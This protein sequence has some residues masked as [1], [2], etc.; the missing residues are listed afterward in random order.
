MTPPRKKNTVILEKIILIQSNSIGQK[1][2]L[3]LCTLVTLYLTQG[4][5]GSLK[6]ERFSRQGVAVR[7]HPELLEKF[8]PKQTT[9]S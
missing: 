1:Q 6:M 8:F 2:L 4:H 5:S 7:S 3:L 9:V